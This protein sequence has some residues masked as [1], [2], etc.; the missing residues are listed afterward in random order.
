MTINRSRLWQPAAAATGGKQ[1]QLDTGN[2]VKTERQS[3]YG[4][5]N[6]SS[7]SHNDEIII[8]AETLELACAP[9]K[10]KLKFTFLIHLLPTDL[11]KVV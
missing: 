2:L 10:V 5:Q 7:Q 6:K 9:V 11:Y 8:Y 4:Q 1:Q 3:F